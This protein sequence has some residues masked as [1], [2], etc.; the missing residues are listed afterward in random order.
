MAKGQKYLH[1]KTFSPAGNLVPR[2]FSLA[3]GWGGPP[4][5]QAREK[6]LGTRLSCWVSEE[7]DRTGMYYRVVFVLVFDR[8]WW[9]SGYFNEWSIRYLTFSEGSEICP[10]L[11]LIRCTRISISVTKCPLALLANFN[12]TCVS[13]YRQFMSQSVPQMLLFKWRLTAAFT[14]S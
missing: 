14:Q 6:V 8:P 7:F 10:G 1:M 3:W 11:T 5:P 4:H 13:E 12:I 2:T 9:P